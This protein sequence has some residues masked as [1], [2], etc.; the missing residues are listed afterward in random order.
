M[1]TFFLQFYL[2]AQGGMNGFVFY[3]NTHTHTH[4][5]TGY[6][7]IYTNTCVWK[8]ICHLPLLHAHSILPSLQQPPSPSGSGNTRHHPHP[9]RTP[10]TAY[11]TP[12]TAHP[13]THTSQPNTPHPTYIPA[14]IV[15]SKRSFA[16]ELLRLATHE[17]I[18]SHPHPK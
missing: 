8:W 10:H 6:T 7:Y 18:L 2:G 11:R 3:T 15:P 1:E 13:T 12:H 16:I 14:A 4:T 17:P 5:H 9:H